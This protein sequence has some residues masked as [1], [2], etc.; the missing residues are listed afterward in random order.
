MQKPVSRKL[1][2]SK[3][4]VKKINIYINILLALFIYINTNTSVAAD[5][6]AEKIENASEVIQIIEPIYLS[7][8]VSTPTAI[9]FIK[10]GDPTPTCQLINQEHLENQLDLVSPDEHA[11]FPNCARNIQGPV[12]HHIGNKYFAAYSYTIEDPKNIFSVSYQ[13]INL[14]VGKF[15]VCNNDEQLD[16]FMKI[17]QKKLGFKKSALNA[18][19]KIGCKADQ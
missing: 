10:K 18:I 14:E 17:N 7:E 15:T 6:I 12:V 3:V 2:M 5:S 1:T 8:K 19:E 4:T 16:E 13:F 11:A 9:R